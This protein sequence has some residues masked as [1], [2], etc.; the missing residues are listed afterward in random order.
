MQRLRIGGTL[1][2]LTF[3][4]LAIRP[5]M[6]AEP[7]EAAEATLNTVLVEGWREL[8]LQEVSGN[9]ALGAKKLLDTPFSLTVVDAED[10]AKRQPA[11]VGQL[12]FND[13]SVLS[14]AP[15]GTVN[16]WGPQIRGIG[17]GSFYVDG[18]PMTLAWGGEFPLEVVEE[19]VAL[20]G[21]SGFMYGFGTPGGVIRY[22]TKKPT[23]APLFTTEVG[24]RSDNLFFGRLDAGGRVGEGDRFGYRINVGGDSGDAYTGAGNDRRIGSLSLDAR[25]GDVVWHG[26]VVFEKAEITHEP[27]YFYWDAFEGDALPK[28]TYDYRDVAVDNSFYRTQTMLAT[29]GVRWS[30]APD[31]SGDVT[32]GYSRKRHWSNKMF[33]YLLDEQGDYQGEA[34]NFAGDLRGYVAQAIA[35]GTARTGAIAHEL[36]FGASYQRTRDL[37]SNEWYWGE[38]FTGNLYERQ[39]FRV[40]RTIDFSLAPLTDDVSQAAVFASDTL[41]FGAHWQ[42]VLGLRRTQYDARD[43]DG[44]PAVASGYRTDALTPTAAV[45]Y[46]PVDG[47]SI[48]GSF[49]EALEAGTRVG[50]TY[51]NVGELLDAT[52]SRQYEAGVKF[53]LPRGGLTTAVFRVERAAQLDQFRDGLRYLT[54]DGLTL[55]DGIEAIG[56]FEVSRQL[57][58]GLGAIYLD[59]SIDEVS[60][61]NQDLQGKRPAGAARLQVVANTEY[62]VPA[63][64]RLTVHAAARYFGDAY[65][66]DDNRVL[67]PSH[68]LVSAGFG[69]RT[70][71]AGREVEVAGNVN[72]LL[73]KKYW[74][75]DSLGEG[76]NAALGVKVF[77]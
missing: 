77:W 71:L 48:Y 6:A 17:V 21:L 25:L 74:E 10:I 40:T 8:D 73:N 9:G 65:Y 75:Q 12:F 67:I 4:V 49:V 32:V 56:S 39:T 46:K 23:D 50:D 13:P 66:G 24:W 76:I 22:D 57:R 34:Y 47:V 33:G 14:T 19:V 41:H 1:V 51:A 63:L 7:P 72:N 42:A 53:D 5:A 61:E 37:W 68:T 52:V 3:N 18:V 29:T 20:K 2:V 59:A 16:W 60:I 31:W 36:V 27:L 64:P 11:S 30:F 54:Q 62:A 28:P 55:Y 70:L 58:L 43:L 35:Q 38:D 26:N 45:I 44:D 69:Y 15:S